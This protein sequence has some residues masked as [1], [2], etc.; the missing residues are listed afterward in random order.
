MTG[1]PQSGSALILIM[2][3]IA[4]FS[5]LVFMFTRSGEQ[6]TG[7]FST[8]QSRM[9]AQQVLAYSKAI[10]DAVSRL[11]QRSISENQLDFR[12]DVVTA[13]YDNEGCLDDS[14]RVFSPQGGKAVWQTPPNNIGQWVITGA[15]RVNHVGTQGTDPENSELLL[16]LPNVPPELCLAINAQLGIENPSG[17]PP[18]TVE[19]VAF[20]TQFTG[21]FTAGG[22]IAGTEL[23]RKSSACFR[24]K[25]SSPPLYHFYHTL[26]AR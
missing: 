8:Q 16:V 17:L 24:E 12:N 7:N 20:A 25:D 13:G 4:L 19:D 14:C 15:A 9:A 18:M 6:G 21:A 10:E 11:L 22:Q 3:T 1:N 23:D 5:A 2:I 26:I